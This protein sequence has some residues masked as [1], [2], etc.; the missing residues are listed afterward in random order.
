MK[1]FNKIIF[2]TILFALLFL[3]PVCVSA[4]DITEFFPDPDELKQKAEEKQAEYDNALYGV[5]ICFTEVTHNSGGIRVSWIVESNGDGTAKV[6]RSSF[7]NGDGS[8]LFSGEVKIE[9]DEV[10]DNPILFYDEKRNVGTCPD[11]IYF[12]YNIETI[13]DDYISFLPYYD[14]DLGFLTG[15]NQTFLDEVYNNNKP[16]LAE[17][18]K[19][20]Q[21]IIDEFDDCTSLLGDPEDQES[22][23]W[24]IKKFSLYFKIAAPIIVLI[25][26][27]VDFVKAI[28]FNDEETMKKAQKKL[29]TRII[30]AIV[31]FMVPDLINLL[32]DIFGLT[33]SNCIK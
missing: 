16:W 33:S 28:M 30:L 19:L 29:T 13:G 15:A 18:V 4:K 2:L 17:D 31:L 11:N 8:W 26:S 14:K 21:D 27:I 24:L 10:F 3:I 22:L 32:F 6:S 9:K 23:A 25:L 7:S 12:K 20:N 5:V 1:R